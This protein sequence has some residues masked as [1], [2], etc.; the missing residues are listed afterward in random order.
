MT[1]NCIVL[2]SNKRYQKY[3]DFMLWQLRNCSI[4]IFVICDKDVIVGDNAIQLDPNDYDVLGDISNYP[5]NTN[6]NG[7]LYKL[8]IPYIPQIS[9]YVKALYIDLDIRL[10]G[11]W[12]DIFEQKQ[13]KPILATKDSGIDQWFVALNH[14]QE[15]YH[16]REFEYANTGVMLFDFKRWNFD[17]DSMKKMIQTALNNRWMYA[18][19]DILNGANIIDCS[20]DRRF[21]TYSHLIDSSTLISHYTASVDAKDR[22]NTYISE[23]LTN[24]K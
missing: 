5:P 20:L 23:T 24:P 2:V 16:N 14:M 10:L 19:Q 7:A 4:D 18:D 9:S 6:L 12:M 13:Q 22:F 11:S 3:L 15:V 1:N 21:N 17:A 8:L